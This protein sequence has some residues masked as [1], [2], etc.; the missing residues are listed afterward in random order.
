[1]FFEP[2]SRIFTLKQFLYFLGLIK[3]QVSG[4]ALHQPPPPSQPARGTPGVKKFY[5]QGWVGCKFYLQD[6]RN[7]PLTS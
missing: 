3:M 7:I 5:S 2:V 4:D 1:M 6:P